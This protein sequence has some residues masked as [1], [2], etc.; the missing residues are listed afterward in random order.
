MYKRPLDLA[1]LTVAHLVLFPVWLLLWTL[2]PALIW[3]EDRGPVFFRQER[4]G[5]DG[6]VFTPL[7]FRTMTVDAQHRGPGWTSDDDQRV[8]RVGRVIRHTALDELPQVVSIWK[9]DMSFVGPRPL[10]IDM[11]DEYTQEEP[12]FP[13]RLKGRPGL[14]GLAQINL[15]RHCSAER[16]LHYDLEYFERASLW[17]DIRLILISGWLTIS[18]GWG[19]GKRRLDE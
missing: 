13:R 17:L 11:H 5:K 4:M 12:R 9:G 16:R 6:R 15:P 8:T 3:L 19:Q 14:T 1:I 18:G 7:K 2:I 10:T